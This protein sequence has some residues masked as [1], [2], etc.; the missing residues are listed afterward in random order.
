MRSISAALSPSA[1][2]SYRAFLM[3]IIALAFVVYYLTKRIIV[4]LLPALAGI[5]SLT[6][7]Y[8]IN[9]PLLAGSI[10]RLFALISPFTRME[11]FQSGIL[12]LPA[13]VYYLSLIGLSLFLTVQ[14]ME[15]RR[16]G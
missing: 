9:L 14:A 3:I 7:L 8:F 2:S 12:D 16:W 5:A 11:N 15:K 10:Q 6:V 1:L 4:A 13:V